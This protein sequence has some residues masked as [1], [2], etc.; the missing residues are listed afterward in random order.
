MNGTPRDAHQAELARCL[1]DHVRR[2]RGEVERIEAA[3]ESPDGLIKATVG[4]DGQV[5]ELDL[6]P[7]ILRTTDSRALADDITSTI[8]DAQ[9]AADREIS[10]LSKQIPRPLPGNV[11]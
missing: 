3:A 8:Q 5:L 10:R 11:S 2:V 6:N 9:R 4:G 7:R 1:A